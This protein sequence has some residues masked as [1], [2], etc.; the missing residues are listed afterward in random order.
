MLSK[1]IIRILNDWQ[2][3]ST[4]TWKIVT[5]AIDA[6]S[7]V[8]LD[9]TYGLYWER[10]L[11]FLKNTSHISALS[12][13][14]LTERM[15]VS[16]NKLRDQKRTDLDVSNQIFARKPWA[17]TN[18]SRKEVRKESTGAKVPYFT[19]QG[20]VHS[21]CFSPSVVCVLSREFNKIV[22]NRLYA[23][24]SRHLYT[25]SGQWITHSWDVISCYGLKEL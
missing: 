24:H 20:M 2:E 5:G 1:L 9:A 16:C 22:E 6:V 14:K 12:N 3:F 18:H 21:N 19:T 25:S 7:H 17:K 13:S 23:L 10:K 4:A 15:F 8:G 11:Y